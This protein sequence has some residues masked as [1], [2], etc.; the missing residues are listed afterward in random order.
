MRLRG[1]ADQTRVTRVLLPSLIPSCPPVDPPPF[2]P[3][4][5]ILPLPPLALSCAPGSPTAHYWAAKPEA[6]FCASAFFLMSISSL[7][8]ALR[9]HGM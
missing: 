4:S 2:L 8:T 9:W 7:S 5:S 6:A 3:P 1:A